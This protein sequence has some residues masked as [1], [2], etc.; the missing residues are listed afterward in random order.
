M[1][2]EFE[3]GKGEVPEGEKVEGALARRSKYR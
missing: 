3:K 1:R 2:E